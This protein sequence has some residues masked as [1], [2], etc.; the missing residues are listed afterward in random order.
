MFELSV[1]SPKVE[2][3]SNCPSDLITINPDRSETV[4]VFPVPVTSVNK[5]DLAPQTPA[6]IALYGATQDVR[7]R[8]LSDCWSL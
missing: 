6:E 8:V 1:E 3:I 2:S 7:D 5:P 4:P